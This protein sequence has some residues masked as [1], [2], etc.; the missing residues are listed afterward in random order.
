MIDN[1]SLDGS[2]DGSLCERFELGL[3]L[4]E[5]AIGL[6]LL[7]LFLL[8]DLRVPFC[9]GND[10]LHVRDAALYGLLRTLLLLLIA[11]VEMF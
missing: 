3:D 2:L 5:Y 6:P 11:L 10:V 8:R 4:L 9:H 1:G 7:P